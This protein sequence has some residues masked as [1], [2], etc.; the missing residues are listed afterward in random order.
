MSALLDVILPVFLVIGFGYAA[1]KRGLF[2]DTAVDGV[3]RYAQNFAAPCLLFRSI[4]GLDLS[5]AYELGLMVSFYL[6]AFVSFGAGMA[7][8]L[9][10]FRRPPARR[11]CNRLCLP[12][13]KLAALGPADHRARFRA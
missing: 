9:F 5:Q 13:F 4:A 8:A 3:M 6:A 10:I 7:G 12:L 1:A 11:C 2:G